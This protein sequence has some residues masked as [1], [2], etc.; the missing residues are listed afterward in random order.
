MSPSKATEPVLF[1]KFS[2][3]KKKLSNHLLCG[4]LC[5]HTNVFLRQRWTWSTASHNSF[6]VEHRLRPWL[7]LLPWGHPGVTLCRN[8]QEYLLEHSIQVSVPRA[9]LLMSFC[10]AGQV[11]AGCPRPEAIRAGTSHLL[12]AIS[13]SMSRM[14]EAGAGMVELSHTGF[15]PVH[16]D[17]H[18]V[19]SVNFRIQGGVHVFD[20]PLSCWC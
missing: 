1:C 10:N 14:G 17:S 7:S 3:K 15:L 8:N 5:E 6:R 16:L 12:F 4:G 19:G 20:L 11:M 2:W 13:T 9:H 18:T